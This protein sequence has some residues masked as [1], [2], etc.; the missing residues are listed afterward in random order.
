MH[1]CK[2]MLC[3]LLTWIISTESCLSYFKSAATPLHVF[4]A[5]RLNAV[6]ETFW[7][8]LLYALNPD[9]PPQNNMRHNTIVSKFRL[10]L[11]LLPLVADLDSLALASAASME[12]SFSCCPDPDPGSICAGFSFSFGSSSGSGVG[13][14]SSSGWQ[15]LQRATDKFCQPF[16]QST[17]CRSL[18]WIGSKSVLPFDPKAWDGI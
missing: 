2:V 6:V 16:Q 14:G 1:L 13:F 11:R 15:A 5:K 3:S 18:V 4:G 7:C 12:Y 8:W 17:F 10:R 9:T